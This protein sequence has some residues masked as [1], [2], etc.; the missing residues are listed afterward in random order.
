MRS[1]CIAWMAPKSKDSV[2]RRDRRGDT[3]KMEAD[4][5]A[6]Q[7]YAWSQG[8]PGATRNKEGST[9]EPLEGVKYCLHLDFWTSGPQNWEKISVCCFQPPS[10]WQ[11]FFP[12]SMLKKLLWSPTVWVTHHIVYQLKGWKKKGG[13]MFKPTKTQKICFGISQLSSGFFEGD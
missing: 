2:L 1:S 12:P 13:L 3:E 11:L 6:M 5:G 8:V 7:P 9:L 4:I 10:V